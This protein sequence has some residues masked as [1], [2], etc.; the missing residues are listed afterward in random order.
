[1]AVNPLK[2][3]SEG[4][5][6]GVHQSLEIDTVP[7]TW[8]Q[9]QRDLAHFVEETNKTKCLVLQIDLPVRSDV[10]RTGIREIDLVAGSATATHMQID[11]MLTRQSQSVAEQT[12]P[13]P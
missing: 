1:M 5:R 6:Y 10:I 12:T 3:A 8:K 4:R 2:E 7:R 13:S 9:A 11:V